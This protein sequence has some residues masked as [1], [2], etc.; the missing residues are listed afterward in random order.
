MAHF[1]YSGNCGAVVIPSEIFRD[2]RLTQSEVMIL[3]V[4]CIYTKNE[5]GKCEPGLQTIAEV[6]GIQAGN[7][8]KVLNT[9][10]SKGWLIFISGKKNKVPNKYTVTIPK[11]GVY[12]GEEWKFRKATSKRLSRQDYKIKR[13]SIMNEKA[14]NP[15][16]PPVYY[17]LDGEE[18]V[19]EVEREEK[20]GFIVP[21]EWLKQWNIVRGGDNSRKTRELREFGVCNE[22]VNDYTPEEGVKDIFDTE[23]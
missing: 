3:S 2:P 18:M 23:E 5:T 8:T 17:E 16:V 13:D 11:E 4:L 6:S 10:V 1:A 22:D 14:K 12:N 21:E 15:E 19:K 7:M 9:L 20:S